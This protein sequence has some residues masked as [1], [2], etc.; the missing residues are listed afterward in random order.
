MPPPPP[1]LSH[2]NGEDR[3]STAPPPADRYWFPVDTLPIALDGTT[4]GCAHTLSR[5]RK[6]WKR[7]GGNA[8]RDKKRCVVGGMYQLHSVSGERGF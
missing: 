7:T 5:C 6:G 3:P 1:K 8:L 2:G 4:H